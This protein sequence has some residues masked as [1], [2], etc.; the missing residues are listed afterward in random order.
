M[1]RQLDAELIA[2]KAKIVA[3]GGYVER[4]VE[5]ATLAL[6]RREKHRLQ[7]VRL[8]EDQVNKSH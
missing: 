5:E 7:Q 8:Y 4:A 3:M 1:E 6:S 2:I